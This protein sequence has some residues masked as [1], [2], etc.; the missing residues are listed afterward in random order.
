[1]SNCICLSE[2]LT[3]NNTSTAVWLNYNPILSQAEHERNSMVQSHLVI[4]EPGGI[5]D[6]NAD[7][8]PYLEKLYCCFNPLSTLCLSA[9]AG[10]QQLDCNIT[11][12]SIL[13]VS[14]LSSLHTLLCISPAL[15]T[16]NLEGCTSLTNVVLG[17]PTL[18]N[19]VL[20]SIL[21]QLDNN[22]A[23]NGR[24]VIHTNQLYNVTNVGLSA[25]NSLSNKGWIVNINS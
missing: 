10:L 24:C 17:S 4:T 16:V 11:M 15:S 20:D 22:G 8:L 2:A 18:V 19:N 9:N 3:S 5:T 13:D 7:C 23:A 14:S 1:M 21:I 25:K 6:F 12:L